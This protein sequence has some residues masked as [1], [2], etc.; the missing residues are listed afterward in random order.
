MRPGQ[1]YQSS[2]NVITPSKPNQLPLTGYTRS[3]AARS[4]KYA[5]LAMQYST[6]SKGGTHFATSTCAGFSS[7]SPFSQHFES[8]ARLGH[9]SVL[10]E[11]LRGITTDSYA[12]GVSVRPFG[13]ST[14][15]T[16][17][18]SA[19]EVQNSLQVLAK[20]VRLSLESTK[21]AIANQVHHLSKAKS[22]PSDLAPTHL[23]LLGKRSAELP[24]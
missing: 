5:D 13:F 19:F 11:P 3:A 16:L 21:P 24:V 10:V 17:P 6:D 22:F 7:A 18:R 9:D 2:H 15:P 4:D 23:S 14:Q 1:T 20:N 12:P 8:Q